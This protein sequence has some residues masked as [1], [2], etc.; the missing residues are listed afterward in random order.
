MKCVLT[1][2]ELRNYEEEKEK[3]IVN[4]ILQ[5]T[6]NAKNKERKK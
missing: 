1:K 5:S 3:R 6:K 2:R 4:N